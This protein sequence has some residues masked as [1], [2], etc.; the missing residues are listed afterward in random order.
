MDEDLDHNK[1]E[2]ADNKVST[3]KAAAPTSQD[4]MDMKT[5][6]SESRSCVHKELFTEAIRSERPTLTE[7]D[8]E[9][10]FDIECRTRFQRK[11][12]DQRSNPMRNS[13]KSRKREGSDRIK[14]ESSQVL[15]DDS[16]T[17]DY[18]VN[19]VADQKRKTIN[20]IPKNR[21]LQPSFTEN[22]SAYIKELLKSKR[23]SKTK[24]YPKDL[25]NAIQITNLEREPMT[26]PKSN[27]RNNE[28]SPKESIR[29]PNE[30]QNMTSP[31][32]PISKKVFLN[33]LQV[34]TGVHL[35]KV[36]S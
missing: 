5:A 32:S 28:F 14:T 9:D 12:N 23:V 15:L 20:I 13:Y 36:K 19:Q 24:N 3:K 8:E 30:K 10:I 7:R 18:R 2:N 4:E 29:S 11:E 35:V 6:I 22:E 21:R 27:K 33:P 16:P 25:V 26:L 31:L 1:N 17:D 34:K